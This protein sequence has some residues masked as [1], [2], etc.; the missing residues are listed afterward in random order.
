MIVQLFLETV[1]YMM[2]YV[3][4]PNAS[5]DGASVPSMKSHEMSME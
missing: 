3:I 2:H 1:K 4:G 5:I